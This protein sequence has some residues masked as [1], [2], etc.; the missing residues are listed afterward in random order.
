MVLG[1]EDVARGPADIGAERHQRLDQ[2]RGLDG[3]VQRAR[4]ARPLEGFGGAELLA[5]SHQARHL[6]FGDVQ[7]LAPEVGER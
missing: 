1:R 7:F 4:D 5:Q 2:H 6:G 3:H